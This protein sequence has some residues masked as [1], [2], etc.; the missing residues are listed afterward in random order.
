MHRT[1]VEIQQVDT[2]RLT[3]VDTNNR[4]E[5]IFKALDHDVVC[6][7]L[8]PSS[9]ELPCS[10]LRTQTHIYMTV[11]RYATDNQLIFH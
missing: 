1:T 6:V 5:T 9:S 7:T 3:W 4:I 10:D 11:D 8:K 2:V